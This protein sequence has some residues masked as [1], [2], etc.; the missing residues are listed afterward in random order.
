MKSGLEDLMKSFIVKIDESLD[1]HGA[2]IKE[3]GTSLRN[4]ERQVGQ[5]ANILSERIPGT[6]PADTKKNPKETVNAVTLRSGQV[7]KE[8]N[9]VQKE[10]TPEKGSG[11]DLKIED[12]KKKKGKNGA[13]KKMK[14]ETSRREEHDV[15]EH[16]PAI[17]FP[18]IS[19]KTTWTSILEEDPYKEEEDR[20]DLSGQAHRALQCNLAKQTPIKPENELGEIRSVP[21][22][23]Q[24]VDQTTVIP[25]G[26]VEDVLVRVEKFVFPVDLIVVKMDVNKEIPLLGRSILA[27][28]RAILDIHERKLMLRVGEEIVTFKMDVE[29]GV[30]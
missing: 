19:I 30:K 29:T 27:T 1:A 11:K 22:S 13:E 26:I 23:L 4:L 14:E 15:S 5:I 7:L 24:L 8:P 3:L 12:D 9:P 20:R 17:P 10:V 6:L 2:A 16:M 18:Q 21:I 28:G 25:K